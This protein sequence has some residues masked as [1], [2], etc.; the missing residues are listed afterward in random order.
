MLIIHFLLFRKGSLFLYFHILNFHIIIL[1]F[2][3]QIHYF[4][5]IDQ[6]HKL[7]VIKILAIFLI[8]IPYYQVYRI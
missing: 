1:N 6:N 7:N 3:N 4:I 5:Y 2:E 8:F